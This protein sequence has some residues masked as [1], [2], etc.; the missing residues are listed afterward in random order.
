M[1]LFLDIDGVLSFD[2]KTFP[3]YTINN[4]H[5]CLGI[6]E[7]PRIVLS[8]RWRL[9]P[10][11]KKDLMAASHNPYW[12][13]RVVDTTPVVFG[14]R[15][16]E[17]AAWLMDHPTSHYVIVDSCAIPSNHLVKT[18]PSVGLDS[19]TALRLSLTVQQLREKY[20]GSV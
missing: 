4:L 8:S 11:W 2:G 6:I 1:I 16:H 14:S 13:S 12:V 17:I 7:N 10:D 19:K 15:E 18:N 5:K 9:N 3:S 20:D